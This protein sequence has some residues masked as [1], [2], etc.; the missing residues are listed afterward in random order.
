MSLYVGNNASW[1]GPVEPTWTS[2]MA[3]RLALSLWRCT[4]LFLGAIPLGGA[5]LRGSRRN[6]AHRGGQRLRD[7]DTCPRELSGGPLAGRGR[8]GQR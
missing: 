4:E 8:R 6:C 3:V 7:P 2:P 1:C 5:L